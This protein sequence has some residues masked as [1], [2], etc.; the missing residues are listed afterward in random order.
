MKKILFFF[1]VNIGLIYAQE[2]VVNV[3]YDLTTKD[4]ATF[5]LKILKSI[6]SNKAYYEGKLKELN[7]AVVIHGGAYKFFV[8]NPAD[9]EFKE[10]KELL[11]SYKDLAKRIKYMSENYE[12]EFLMCG[13]G[14][15]KHALNK[16]GIYTFIKVI[17]N[18]SIGLIDK[19]DAG[20]A[21]I[22]VAK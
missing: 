16:N 2:N 20:Y 3:V 4:L 1:F 22:P 10:D 15:Q 11:N 14:M 17:K 8:K 9:S 12:V 6:V 7:V 5:E 19:Q 18:A 21:Y 13:V